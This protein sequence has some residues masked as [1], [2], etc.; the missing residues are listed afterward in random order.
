MKLVDRPPSARAGGQWSPSV[1]PVFTLTLTLTVHP[2]NNASP[3]TRSAVQQ[4]RATT[5]H[6]PEPVKVPCRPD[7]AADRDRQSTYGLHDHRPSLLSAVAVI[8]DP[9]IITSL[10]RWPAHCLRLHF[11][12]HTFCAFSNRPAIVPFGPAAYRLQI[13]ALEEKKARSSFPIA[14][15]LVH[16][17][18]VLGTAIHYTHTHSRAPRYT[19]LSRG[20]GLPLVISAGQNLAGTQKYPPPTRPSLSFRSSRTERQPYIEFPFLFTY[21]TQATWVAVEA[22]SAWTSVAYGWLWFRAIVA[23]A[24][25][26]LDTFTAVNLLAF[27]KWSSSVQ[28]KLEF[29]YSKWIFAACILLSWVL[30]FYEWTRAIRTIRRGGVA[31][32][33]LDPLA[34]NL[35][36]MRSQGWRRFLVFSALTKS[37][38]GADYV[39]LFVYFSFK[40]A[41]RVLLAEGPRQVVNGLTLYAVMDADLIVHGTQSSSNASFVQFFV[42]L[43]ALANEN[44]Q[45]TL[46]YFAMLF[47]LV[48]WAFSA[49]SLLV[50]AILYITFL[51]H[52]IPQ[53]DG[54]LRTYCKRKVDRRLEKIVEHKIK[55]A[56]EEEERQR[57]KAEKKADTR[58]PRKGEAL[59]PPAKLA[60]QPTLPQFDAEHI[61]QDEKGPQVGLTR[62][63]TGSSA[64]T[65]PPYAQTAIHPQLDRQPTLPGVSSGKPF[66]LDRT[67]TS[68]SG[69]SSAP[70]YASSAP[71]LSNTGFSGEDDTP[72]MPPVAYRQ[73]SNASFGR[74]LPD[75]SM[76][77]ST[78]HSD[79]AYTPT[80]QG[81]PRSFTPS[82]TV[83]SAPPPD[84]YRQPTGSNSDTGYGN[85]PRS[86]VTI[87]SPHDAHP[88]SMGRLSQRETQNVFGPNH[89]GQASLSSRRPVQTPAPQ[90]PYDQQPYNRSTQQRRPSQPTS[91]YR[92]Y[93]PSAVSRSQMT[94]QPDSYEMTAQPSYASS[95]L[96]NHGSSNTEQYKAFSP[97]AAS[98]SAPLE[99]RRN[100]TVAGEPGAGGNYFGHVKAAS[101]RSFT[102][103]PE[104]QHNTGY[105]DLLDAYGYDSRESFDERIDPNFSRPGLAG[106]PPRAGTGL[107]A[108]QQQQAPSRHQRP[109]Y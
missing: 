75:R 46:V 29:K 45:Q 20:G 83:S 56:V 19:G 47:T 102:A 34:V 44:L 87:I 92:P 18:A 48:I 86:A 71:L 99:P 11:R 21:R 16:L 43:G 54:R 62:Q 93:V 104:Q 49:I 32:S 51:W 57:R 80:T 7:L 70:S 82:S 67:N 78:V 14:V 2:I 26:A 33:F 42:N 53:R 12:Y 58:R 97:S 100:V 50:A 65:L 1:P 101:Q 107:S 90:T 95:R 37:K 38:K 25:Y 66:M 17:P 74:P 98:T 91:S 81:P 106:G 69:V 94:P 31:Q 28:P 73:N 84:Q 40:G 88:F 79:R 89:A 10:L 103:P 68:A 59:P 35:Q 30:A 72:Q 24:V 39:A 63:D 9:Y 13:S 96:Q 61:V 15:F 5:A 27:N 64:S 23:V 22:T 6:A 55:A 60:R 76:T 36:S 8:H 85:E 77:Q 3:P 4:P 52:H 109:A 41:I 105:D 108:L